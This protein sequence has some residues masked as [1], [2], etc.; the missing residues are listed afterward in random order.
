MVAKLAAEATKLAQRNLIQMPI[1]TYV[2]YCG[3]HCKRQK[4]KILQCNEKAHTFATPV[5]T[6]N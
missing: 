4:V 5:L 3:W 1:S 2:E 6:T